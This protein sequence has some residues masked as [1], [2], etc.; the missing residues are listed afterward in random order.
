MD[1]INLPAGERMRQESFTSEKAFERRYLQKQYPNEYEFFGMTDDDFTTA[2]TTG[3]W[4]SLLER[5]KPDYY[6]P[7][8]NVLFECC[9]T[10]S[11]GYLRIRESKPLSMAYWCLKLGAKGYFSIWNSATE[12]GYLIDAP[13]MFEAVTHKTTEIEQYDNKLFKIRPSTLGIA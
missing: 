13:T 9:G 11:S 7:S 12:Q 8:A 4:P 3:V 6:V 2:K 5:E 10:G 1:T